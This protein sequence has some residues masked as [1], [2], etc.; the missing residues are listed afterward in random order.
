MHLYEWFCKKIFHIFQ[1]DRKIILRIKIKSI[2][3]PDLIIRNPDLQEMSES[4]NPD[5]RT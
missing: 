5:I 3:N 1:F 2:R 4:K